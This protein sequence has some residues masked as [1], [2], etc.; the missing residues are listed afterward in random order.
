[1]FSIKEKIINILYTPSAIIGTLWIFFCLLYIRCRCKLTGTEYSEGG[2]KFGMGF[3]RGYYRV[4]EGL[5]YYES[6]EIAVADHRGKCELLLT[7]KQLKKLI[8]KKD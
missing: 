6:G 5:R 3:P 7:P 1:M 8:E 2:Y 4:K